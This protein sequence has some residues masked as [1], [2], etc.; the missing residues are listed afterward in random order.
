MAIEPAKP[1]FW[2]TFVKTVM[3]LVLDFCAKMILRNVG[4]FKLFILKIVIKYGRREL[5]EAVSKIMHDLDEAKKNAEIVKKYNEAIQKPG[6][7]VEEREK[8]EGDYLNG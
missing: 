2:T 4:G 1:S 7:T 5:V 6:Q 8:A 3:P